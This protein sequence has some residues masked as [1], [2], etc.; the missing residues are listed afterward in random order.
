MSSLQNPTI[1]RSLRGHKDAITSVAFHP[2]PSE[3][4]TRK[5]HPSVE[6][7]QIASASRDGGLTLW[8]YQSVASEVRAFR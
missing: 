1:D 6:Q 3:L 7:V 5:Q 8:N 4:A 2:C